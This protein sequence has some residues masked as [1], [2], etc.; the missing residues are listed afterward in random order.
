MKVTDPDTGGPS[1][2]LGHQ[3]VQVSPIGL[4]S[5]VPRLAVSS[6]E[7]CMHSSLEETASFRALL[8]P[9]HCESHS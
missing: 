7:E 4:A 3:W 1:V 9:P 6:S 5:V 2:G 8:W